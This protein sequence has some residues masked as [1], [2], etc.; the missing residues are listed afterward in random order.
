MASPPPTRSPDH[1]DGNTLE[2]T[3]DDR[4]P[5]RPAVVRA[6]LQFA[7]RLAVAINLR[8]SRT[9]IAFFRHRRQRQRE[10]DAIMQRRRAKENDGMDVELVVPS[11]D[12]ILNESSGGDGDHID[13]DAIDSSVIEDAAP[14]QPNNDDNNDDMDDDRR[15]GEAVSPSPGRALGSVATVVASAATSFL[16]LSRDPHGNASSQLPPSASMMIYLNCYTK[17]NSGPSRF[18]M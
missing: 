7:S 4:P 6:Q 8:R 13:L 11:D 15:A 9:I 17:T 14:V 5:R 12:V 3:A 10:K 16:S 2:T 18:S 1:A